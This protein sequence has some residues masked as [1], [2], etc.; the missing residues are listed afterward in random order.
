MPGFGLLHL[1]FLA[2]FSVCAADQGHGRVTLNG[3]IQA[4]AC[5]VSTEDVWQE[6]SFGSHP[7]KDFTRYSATEVSNDFSLNLVN[8]ILEKEKG[9]EWESV[10]ITFDG[11]REPDDPSLF[12]LS[13]GGAG[14]AMRI[15]DDYG[16]P[17]IAGEPMPKVPLSNEATNLNYHLHLVA[18]GKELHAGDISTFLRFMVVYQ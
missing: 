14:I 16:H 3:Q 4:A 15:T 10:E 2:A 8:C 9:G 5:T 1:L 11:P 18:N 7:L 6:I 13:G 12:M 17:A